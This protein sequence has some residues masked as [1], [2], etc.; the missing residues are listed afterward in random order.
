MGEE[1]DAGGAG[2]TAEESGTERPSLANQRGVE[3]VYQPAEDSDLLARTARERVEAGDTVLDVGTGSGYVAATLADAG[4]RAV[5]VDVSPL[6]CQEA[7]E[8]G[9]PVV[10]GD[11]VE[12]FRTDA[13]DLVA[14]NPPYL[15][16]P[17]EQEWD[18]W[19]EHALSGGDDGRR[20]VD[21]FLETVERV[22]APAGEALMLVSSLTDP[23]AV[24]EYAGEYGLASEQLA[25]EKHPY[26]ALVVLR[27]YRD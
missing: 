12:P 21:P 4:A 3:S 2:E 26:E 13:F 16:T 5:G 18:D 24:R 6:A 15:P 23:E 9:V 20:L 8:N 22:L 19:M 14:F 1:S 25:S 17:S 10:R 11:L 7:A 27:F